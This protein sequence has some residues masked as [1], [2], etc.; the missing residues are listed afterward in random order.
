MLKV[1]AMVS[2]IIYQK[3]NIHY[4]LAYFDKIYEHGV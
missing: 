3:Y 1:M 2:Q 4:S